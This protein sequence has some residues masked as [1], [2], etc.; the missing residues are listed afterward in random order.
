MK[1]KIKK[2]FLNLQFIFKPIYWMPLNPYSDHWDKV[3]NNLIDSDKGELGDVNSIDG[4]IY[5]I[6]FGD[7]EVWIQNYPYSYGH[8]HSSGGETL[9]KH[10]PSRLTIKKL[11]KMVE[12]KKR[13]K[14]AGYINNKFKW[15]K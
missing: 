4:Q 2:F 1:E 10:R 5:T 3:L 6:K 15:V 8:I 7:V 9:P 14:S 13:E 11:E 12:R